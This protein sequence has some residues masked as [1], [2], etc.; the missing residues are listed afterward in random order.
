MI[1]SLIAAFLL[2]TAPALAQGEF[3]PQENREAWG[4]AIVDVETTGLEAG[5]H[6][7]IDLG[8]IY[9][10]L[11][12]NELGRFFIRINPDHPE[13]ATEF[14]RGINGFE[15]ERWRELE[16]LDEAEAV[17]RFLAFHADTAGERTMLFT[18]YNAYFD[19]NFLDALL[20][21]HGESFRDHFTY[22]LLDLPS[23]AWG[24]GIQDLMNADVAGALGLR[25][26]TSD[27]LEHTG[28]SGA[29]WNL[30]LYRAL[31]ERIAAQ[32]GTGGED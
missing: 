9:T 5:H 6:E 15:E 26:E 30:A 3:P 2:V 28:L 14:V 17:E 25:A 18:A 13:L 31:Q 16:A 10:D 22:F 12:G 19:R 4:L 32:A 21:Q 8:A 1:R 24:A 7:M 29:E 23:L 27:P 20:Q 11:D